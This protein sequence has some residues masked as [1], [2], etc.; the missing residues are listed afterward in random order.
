MM[1]PLVGDDQPVGVAVESDADIGAPRQHLLPH[2]LGREGAA[3]AV[4]VQPVRRDRD[5]EHLGA[6]L[7]Q[8]GRRNLVGGAMR[9]VDDDP[10]PIQ[11]QPFREALLHELDI[12]AAGILEPLGATE[13]ARRG[14]AEP[15]FAERF[16]DF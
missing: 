4:D 7:P 15:P 3:F 11:P 10:Q 13:L 6:E 12:A 8:H 14:A 16:L 5:R 9:A 1:P 2:L